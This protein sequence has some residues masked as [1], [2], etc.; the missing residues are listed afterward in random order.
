MF[1]F[2]PCSPNGLEQIC[3]G[4]LLASR[5]VA[6]RNLGIDFDPRVGWNEVFCDEKISV[7]VGC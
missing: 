2:F 6:G 1:R 7:P 3:L 5:K 4:N